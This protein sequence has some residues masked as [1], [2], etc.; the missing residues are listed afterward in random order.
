M[1]FSGKPSSRSDRNKPKGQGTD[2]R[3]PRETR[4]SRTTKDTRDSRER[5][6]KTEKPSPRDRS[7]RSEKPAPR[8]RSGRSEKPAPRERSGR[9]ET[10]SSR[11][12]SSKFEKPAPRGSRSGKPDFKERG[13]RPARGERRPMTDPEDRYV[14][15]EYRDRKGSARLTKPYT[16]PKTREND[17][18]GTIRLN[19]FLSNAGI[20]SRREADKLI[21]LGL[22]SVNGKVVK[23]LGAKVDPRVDVVKYD[24]RT[25]RPEPM[26]Y[27]LLNKP[28]D[29]ITATDDPLERKTV[30]TL[31]LTACKERIYPVGRLDR[32]TT[33]LLLFTNDGDL[34][35][36]LTTPRFGFPKLYHVETVDK[37][38]VAQL[39]EIRGGVK[40][41]DGFIKVDEIEFVGDGKDPKSVGIR[42]NNARTSV[43]RNI[44]EHFGHK[45]KKLDRVMYAGMSKK[46][47]ARGR[48]RH[49]T[50][51]EVAF[52]KMIR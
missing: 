44:F 8:E 1:A 23:E 52:L 31:I 34:A 46:D 33:G 20:A 15:E 4:D 36:K 38:T 25:L 48:Y 37:V 17:T 47:L 50:E 51:K 3:K 19:R 32:N 11:E 6:S 5:G 40:T 45:I 24:D 41:I 28:K 26:R 9:T 12:R 7:S 10:A 30:M 35:K 22:V 16:P 27:V 2:K 43:I 42:L 18:D 49:L 14:R 29:Y 21:E 39:Q 13:A